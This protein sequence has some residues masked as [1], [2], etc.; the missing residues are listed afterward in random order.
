MEATRMRQIIEAP[1]TNLGTVVVRLGAFA[2]EARAR[3]LAADARR[4]G[5][6]QVRV[7]PPTGV[8]APLHTVQ[9]GPYADP[10][11]AEKQ[12]GRA[13]EVLGVT[14]ERIHTP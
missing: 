14:A 2:D 4:A 13:E 9:L 1:V 12:A 11:E 10:A 5:F 6:S 7:I 3:G 8:G